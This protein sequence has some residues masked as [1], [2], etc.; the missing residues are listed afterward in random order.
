[1]HE[2][3]RAPSTD[4]TRLYRSRDELYATDMLIAALVGI[5]F[6][7]WLDSHPGTVDDIASHFGFHRRPVD[8]MTT[9]FV[10]MELLER[11]GETLR[12]S[13][14]GREHLVASSPWFM[15]PYF[16]KVT[17]RPIARDLLDVLRTGQP[18]R[19]ASRKDEPD[20][21]R[22]M[23]G[24]KFADEFLAAMDVRGRITGQALAAN[25]PFDRHSRL[26]DVGGGSGIFACAVAA[27]VPDLRAT[28]LEKPPVDR[29]SRRRIEAWGLQSRV[30]VI[31]RDMLTEPLPEG[32]D[33]HLFSNV[34]H[35]WDTDIVRQLL[36]ASARSLPRGGAIVIHDA[37]LN[38]GKTGPL[39]I[40]AYSV[41]LMHVTQGRCYSTAE[42]E[43]WLRAA[44]FD[45]PAVYP[46]AVERSALVAYRAYRT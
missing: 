38:A 14:V 44:G 7:T 46:T 23:E 36:E 37:F 15:G 43:G 40:A 27:R 30:D 42:M 41:L 31:A 35:D 17:D 2:L 18:A 24:E 9:L 1:M 13:A 21:H 3:T 5:D 28:V 10:A 11:S 34:L 33:V 8:V 25:V 19:F 16:P 22:A 32:Y 45:G 6:F 26:L 20:W 4:A 12:L 39:E 29:I